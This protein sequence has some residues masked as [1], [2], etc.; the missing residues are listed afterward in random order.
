MLLFLEQ[1]GLGAIFQDGNVRP[2][3]LMYSMTSGFVLSGVSESIRNGNIREY[4][5]YREFRYG[6]GSHNSSQTHATLLCP[7]QFELSTLCGQ[8]VLKT[9]INAIFEIDWS[10]SEISR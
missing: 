3:C 9:D 2:D 4:D 6:M 8:D 10:G 5:C 7:Q 1:I